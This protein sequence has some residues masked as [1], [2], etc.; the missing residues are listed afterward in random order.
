MKPQM[1]GFWHPWY[2][3]FDS[4][5]SK[6][7]SKNDKNC[8]PSKLFSKNDK[9]WCACDLKRKMSCDFGAVTNW[10][11]RFPRNFKWQTRNFAH[12]K[13]ISIDAGIKRTKHFYSL[14]ILSQE[15]Y[16]YFSSNQS[17]CIITVVFVLGLK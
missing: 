10:T 15:K 2:Q 16:I 5:P 7:F 13:C 1:K 9:D 11:K 4:R 14:L 6:L 12:T 3:N 17:L 8:R